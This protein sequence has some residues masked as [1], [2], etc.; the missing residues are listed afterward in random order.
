[1]LKKY[2]KHNKAIVNDMFTEF[3]DKKK[4]RIMVPIGDESE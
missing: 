4:S 1:M 3:S 2:N